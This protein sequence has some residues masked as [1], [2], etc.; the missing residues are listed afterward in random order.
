V[1]RT[2]SKGAKAIF[3]KLALKLCFCSDNI[4]WIRLISECLR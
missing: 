1:R 4:L 3:S 2:K